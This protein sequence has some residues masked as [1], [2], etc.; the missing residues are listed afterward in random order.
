M[1]R[2]AHLNLPLLMPAQAQKHVTVN[3]ALV[4]LDALTQLR[5]ISS[6][7]AEPP[8]SA[9]EG[10]GYLV[11]GGAAGDW[12]GKAGQ[13]AI[14]SN[15]GWLFVVPPAGLSAWD[16]S[17]G[18]RQTF[19]GAGWVAD[20]VA[21]S[22]HGAATAWKVIEFDHVVVAGGSNVTGTAIPAQ[23]QVV[24]VTGRVVGALSGPG[25]TGWRIGVAGAGD[26]YGSGLGTAV[27]SYALG[28]S[29]APVTY[30]APTPLLL[31]AE[32]GAFAAGIVRLCLHL[33]MLQPPRPI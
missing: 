5:V 29:G 27:N 28:L 23:A 17:L 8:A 13:I 30:Y 14:W 20:A 9:A 16:D 1:A 22:A 15:G 33:V 24:G 4:R 10:A 7:L 6:V 26:R 31:T 25:L 2:T 3:E 18:G 12:A 32:G 21:V 19:D 11:P